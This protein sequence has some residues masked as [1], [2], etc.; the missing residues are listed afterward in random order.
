MEKEKQL[1]CIINADDFGKSNEVNTAI[2]EC[3]SRKIIHQTSIMVNMPY[4]KEAA[5]MARDG[6]YFDKVGLHINLVEGE[7]LTKGIRMTELCDSNGCFSD[8]IMRGKKR[9]WVDGFTKKCIYEEMEEQIKAYLDAGFSLKNMD[10]H[11][12]SHINFSIINMAIKLASKYDFNSIR[13]SRNIPS[14]QISLVKRVYKSIINKRILRFNQKNC[15]DVFYFGA[16]DDVIKQIQYG[17]ELNGKLE[18][19]V[20]PIMQDGRLSDSI[21]RRGVDAWLSEIEKLIRIEW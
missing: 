11:M 7:P 9:F 13:L 2:D 17:G 10:S 18:I 3:F 21:T 14:N 16:M 15:W 1:K 4:F 12:H 6:G 20:H 5:Q 8:V 19:M